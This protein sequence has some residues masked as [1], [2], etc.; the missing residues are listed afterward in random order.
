MGKFSWRRAHGGVLWSLLKPSAGGEDLRLSSEF[1]RKHLECGRVILNSLLA[2]RSY[3]VE[4]GKSISYLPLLR[5]NGEGIT[6]VGGGLSA[7]KFRFRKWAPLVL[8]AVGLGVL[9]GAPHVP[10]SVAQCESANDT[11]DCAGAPR[12]VPIQWAAGGTDSTGGADSP[13]GSDLTVGAAAEDRAAGSLEDA[14]RAARRG[15]DERLFGL[16]MRGHPVPRTSVSAK[17]RQVSVRV[18]ATPGCDLAHLILNAVTRLSGINGGAPGGGETAI[19][20]QAWDRQT[21]RAATCH[22][23]IRPPPGRLLTYEEWE[24]EME[25]EREGQTAGEGEGTRAAGGSRGRGRTGKTSS[26]RVIASQ[27]DIPLLYVP[28]EVIASKWYGESERALSAVFAAAQAFPNG[29]I[30]FLD[31]VDALATARDSD[32]H[33]ATRRT[34]SIDGFERNSGVVLIAATNRK[35]DLDPALLSRFDAAVTFGLPD[36]ET[37]QKIVAHMSGRDIRDVC[38]QAERRWASQLIRSAQESGV[39]VEL[40]PLT[41]YVESAAK[42]KRAVMRESTLFP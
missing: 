2:S 36:A 10:P 40:P 30:V 35:E 28:L 25:E 13:G 14:V 26:A 7:S 6:N 18:D 29:A 34:L 16:S 41:L 38:E 8:T 12:V 42:R 21:P 24:G 19:G 23:H 4:A 11:T 37:R 5:P 31:E 15:L 17:G 3:G 20:L 39:E 22:D 32:M 1:S 9:V 33:E 27:V